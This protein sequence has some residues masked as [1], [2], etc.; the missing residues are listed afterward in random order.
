MFQI[1]KEIYKQKLKLR[2]IIN[3]IIYTKRDIMGFKDLF[4]PKYEHSDYKVRIESLKE[5]DDQE[6]ITNMA[7]NDKNWRVRLE[8]VKKV[9]SDAVLADIANNDLLL[10]GEVRLEATNNINDKDIL[11]NIAKDKDQSKDVRLKAIEKIKDNESYLANIGKECK[12]DEFADIII[13]NIGTTSVLADIAK[14]TPSTDIGYKALEKI[15]DDTLLSDIAINASNDNIGLKAVEK[16]NDEKILI[17]I[18]KNSKTD[19]VSAKAVKKLMIPP[20]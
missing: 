2:K 9:N 20:F 8:A 19:S 1:K 16:I 6:I 13:N 14:N 5:L 10:S 18:V 11:F 17:E 15:N 12:N 4:K 3:K 7:K